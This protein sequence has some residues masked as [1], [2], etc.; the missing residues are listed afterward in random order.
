MAMTFIERKVNNQTERWD[1]TVT[2]GDLRRLLEQ[3]DME[4]RKN[5]P[6]Y[7]KWSVC[8]YDAKYINMA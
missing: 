6:G 1:Y 2:D 4:V 3:V 5:D 7:G 8:N